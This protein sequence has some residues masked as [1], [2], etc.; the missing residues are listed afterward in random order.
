M[1]GLQAIAKFEYKAIE[2]DGLYYYLDNDSNCAQVAPMPSGGYSGNIT[3]PSSFIYNSKKYSVTSIG[4]SAFW[5]CSSLTSV[6][7]PNSVSSIEALTFHGCSNLSSLMV[8]SGNVNY[9]SRDNCNAIIEKKTNTLIAGCPNTVIPNS[10]TSIGSGAFCGRIGLIS[11]TIPSSV[12]S[13]GSSAF[14]ECLDLTSIVVNS[15]NAI[16]DSRDNCN[17]IIEKMTNTMIAGCKNSVI[18]NSVTSIG[19]SAF[20][21]YSNLP[22]IT[23]PNSVTSIGNS[24]FSGCS[25]LPSITIPNSVT[26]IGNSAF[27]GC[28]SLSSITIPNSVTTIHVF[29]VS[30]LTQPHHRS[31]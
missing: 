2:V 26:S 24:A 7:I 10:V 25:S 14:S 27:S 30:F 9:D 11:V 28:S 3:I 20:S 19:N 21:G 6:T 12:T 23:I 22:S 1:T 8:E 17:A 13:I 15:E 5:G 31:C 16:Y 29:N 4:I 18:P